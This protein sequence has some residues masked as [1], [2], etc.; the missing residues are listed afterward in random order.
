MTGDLDEALIQAIK[1]ATDP[2]HELERVEY[3]SD[4][5]LSDSEQGQIPIQPKI[6]AM[7]S[8]NNLESEELLQDQ[9]EL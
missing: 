2:D 9:K 1:R 4:V 3:D 8:D 7:L 5:S 6:D